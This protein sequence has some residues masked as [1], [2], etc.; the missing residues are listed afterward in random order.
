MAL[1]YTKKMLTKVQK[2]QQ[3]SYIWGMEKQL[4]KDKIKNLE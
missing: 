2:L 1:K 3:T 4:H